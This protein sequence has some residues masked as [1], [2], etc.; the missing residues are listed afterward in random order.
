MKKKFT[1]LGVLA[2]M[3]LIVSVI[4]T[5]TVVP[6]IAKSLG[7]GY[8]D[9]LVIGVNPAS[10]TA[11]ITSAG[12]L[13]VTSLINTGAVGGSAIL[14]TTSVTSPLFVATGPSRLYSRTKAQINALATPAVGDAYY[15]SDC[16]AVTMCLSTGTVVKSFV[17]VDDRTAVCD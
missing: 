6:S 17:K 10:P 15:C 12:A 1:L 9:A 2:T 11:S 5:L 14:A 8:F 16:V 7:W 3:L 4:S 13:T